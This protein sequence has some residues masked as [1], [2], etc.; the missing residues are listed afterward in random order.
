MY[1]N[2]EGF[3]V[4]RNVQG[5]KTNKKSRTLKTAADKLVKN[6]RRRTRQTGIDKL[7]DRPK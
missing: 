7:T 5:A 3:L 1:L 2:N 4:H 6:I